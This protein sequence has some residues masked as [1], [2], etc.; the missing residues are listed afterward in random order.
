MTGLDSKD[1]NPMM[2]IMGG[3]FSGNAAAAAA[4]VAASSAAAAAALGVQPATLLTA[5][6]T[7]DLYNF[8]QMGGLHQQ[9][10]Q[11]SA[12]S[13][14]QNY[15]NI[16][17]NEQNIDDTTST[18]AIAFNNAL[19][20][21]AAAAAV[22]AS[23]GSTTSQFLTAD[24]LQ[25]QHLQQQQALFNQMNNNS[26]NNLDHNEENIAVNEADDNGNDED[27]DDD[28]DLYDD[29]DL[30][31]HKQEIINIDDFVMMTD[32]NSYD[33]TDFVESMKAGT[34][35]NELENQ[36]NDENIPKQLLET[37]SISKESDN[38][39][40]LQLLQ[41]IQKMSST[42]R[43]SLPTEM[44][45]TSSENIENSE[46]LIKNEGTDYPGSNPQFSLRK[47]RKIE[48][49][50]RPGLV[51]KTPIAYRGNIDP[52]VIPI[53]KDGMGMFFNFDLIF[54]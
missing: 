18:A 3:N 13:V 47:T 1:L 15:T 46:I 28:N 11:Q 37:A 32:S 39:N 41:E 36:I 35:P 4:A 16:D 44:D 9:L 12:A 20:A 5:A 8:A 27:G 54:I 2:G 53:E 10:L 48:P 49:I 24:D 7:N 40:D 52:S 30:N 14:F 33:G 34:N 19:N 50:N 17:N 38:K 26:G 42:S 31:H 6:N 25:R 29:D 21:A 22:A 43:A 23:A 45:N 51:L